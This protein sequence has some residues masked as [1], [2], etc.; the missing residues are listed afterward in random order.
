MSAHQRV[1]EELRGR[2]SVGGVRREHGGDEGE[3]RSREVAGEGRVIVAH[4]LDEELGP[5]GGVEGFGAAAGHLVHGAPERPHVRSVRVGFP[6]AQLGGHVQRGADLRVGEVVAL[7]QRLGDAE[8]A[9]LDNLEGL[10]EEDVSGLDVAM[11]DSLGVNVRETEEELDDPTHDGIFGEG[12]TAD[13]L[14]QAGEVATFAVRHDDAQLRAGGSRGA[15]SAK[16]AV[17]A[18]DVG[19]VGREL[20]HLSLSLHA[21]SLLVRHRHTAKAAA[22]AGA[23]IAAK[24]KLLHRVALARLRVPRDA[25]AS[26]G[27]AADDLA[28]G[29]L[30]GVRQKRGGASRRLLRGLALRYARR[31]RP[32]GLA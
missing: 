16:H 13:A 23:R 27:A 10:G 18:H 3:E 21:L 7:R 14:Q 1:T 11:Q 5:S 20:Q 29:E 32:G 30:G 31:F 4:D 9:N 8:V 15:L 17:E 28:E 26:L 24:G 6:L 19:V 22:E 2:G 25:H 12:H